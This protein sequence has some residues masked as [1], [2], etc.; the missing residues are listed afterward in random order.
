MPT[1]EL[2]R[3]R[4]FLENL[5]GNDAAVSGVQDMSV[6][7]KSPKHPCRFMSLKGRGIQGFPGLLGPKPSFSRILPR[8]GCCRLGKC[9]PTIFFDCQGPIGFVFKEAVTL[10]RVE[11]NQKRIEFGLVLLIGGNGWVAGGKALTKGVDFFTVD[12][13]S[14]ARHRNIDA[15]DVRGGFVAVQLDLWR[16]QLLDLVQ[17]GPCLFNRG[18]SPNQDGALFG[19]AD[20]SPSGASLIF[21]NSSPSLVFFTDF[22]RS[23]S[24]RLK[25]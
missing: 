18:E 7:L 5:H 12:F 4:R 17:L 11:F 13:H 19:G 20:R 25:T 10:L 22:L 3:G 21:G 15:Y 24:P 2:S 6:K 16:G 9:R 8:I 14:L 1:P 23:S